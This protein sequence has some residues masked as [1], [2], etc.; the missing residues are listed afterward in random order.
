MSRRCLSEFVLPA[1]ASTNLAKFVLD[2]APTAEISVSRL[3]TGTM[4][5]VDNSESA[6]T[7]VGVGRVLGG[8]YRLD[9]LIAS[10]GM[11]EVYRATRLHI[12]DEVA[13]KVLRHE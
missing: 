1:C 9:V 3:R 7:G 10:G 8:R 4:S 5:I 6:D 12:G 2:S 11:G 13:V